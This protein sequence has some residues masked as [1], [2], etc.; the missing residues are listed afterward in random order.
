MGIPHREWRNLHPY[1]DSTIR[2]HCLQPVSFNQ[3]KWGIQC[4]YI[5]IKIQRGCQW[6][7]SVW[8]LYRK[9]EYYYHRRLS[10]IFLFSR[11]QEYYLSRS[12]I[13]TRSSWIIG[14]AKLTHTILSITAVFIP[15]TRPSNPT[16]GHHELPGWIIAS[17]WIN[18]FEELRVVIF[19]STADTIP[20]VTV[21][22]RLK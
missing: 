1:T 19:R 4:L 3:C 18:P 2:W 17:V 14:V 8:W 12:T 7:T 13:A 6:W 20:I 16:S 9:S 22:G 21:F 15:T 5:Q 10:I 11:E